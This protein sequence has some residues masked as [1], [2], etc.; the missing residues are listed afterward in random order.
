M[1]RSFTNRDMGCP[2]CSRFDLRGSI[3]AVRAF[4]T[5][6]HTTKSLHSAPSLIQLR[7]VG[8]STQMRRILRDRGSGRVPLIEPCGA[9]VAG[10]E[11]K[12]DTSTGYARSGQSRGDYSGDLLMVEESS[13]VANGYVRAVALEGAQRGRRSEHGWLRMVTSCMSLR[14]AEEGRFLSLASERIHEIFPAHRSV[15]SSSSPR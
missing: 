13:D 6:S 10:G 11:E 15:P 4:R 12:P 1:R 14:Q 8:V 5:T 7:L 9:S 3:C 2:S